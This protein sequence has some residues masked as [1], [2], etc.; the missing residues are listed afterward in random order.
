NGAQAGALTADV[1]GGTARNSDPVAPRYQIAANLAAARSLE[2]TLP[3]AV[4]READVVIGG[5]DR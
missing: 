5:R 1:L 2:I 4:V 3:D